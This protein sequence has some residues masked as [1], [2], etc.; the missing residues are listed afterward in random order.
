MRRFATGVV[1]VGLAAGLVGGCSGPTRPPAR[2]ARPTPS[3]QPP[4][5]PLAFA[6][7]GP[8]GFV[9]A[10]AARSGAIWKT[11]DGGAHWQRLVRLPLPPQQEALNVALQFFTPTRGWIVWGDQVWWTATGGRTWTSEPLPPP[12]TTEAALVAFR[13]SRAGLAVV[14]SGMAAGTEPVT[15]YA[16]PDGG[17]HWTRIRAQPG[18][19]RGGAKTGLTLASSR[20]AWVVVGSPVQ[21]VS[22]QLWGTTDGGRR[23]TRQPLPDPPGWSPSPQGLWSLAAPAVNP[24]THQA[25]VFGVY[26][27]G[28]SSAA[29]GW[30]QWHGATATWT[31]GGWVQRQTSVPPTAPLVDGWVPGSQHPW[32]GVG[33]HVW[34]ATDRAG[35]PWLPCRLPAVAPGTVLQQL[36]WV[37]G[38]RAGVLW[39]TPQGNTLQVLTLAPE[40]PAASGTPGITGA[41]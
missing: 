25:V 17:G 20:L 13:P 18:L 21:G 31:W 32:V 24:V 23:W 29:V 8:V 30:W 5:H 2:V 39:R 6:M 26:S 34:T 22:S 3:M 9:V 33:H 4:Q 36:Q 37:T 12:T 1:V 16:T 15:L 35:T 41:G 27:T 40:A 7:I 10:A 11:P 28:S 38:T 14:S 19:P